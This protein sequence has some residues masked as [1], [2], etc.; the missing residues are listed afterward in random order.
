LLEEQKI[1]ATDATI[2]STTDEAFDAALIPLISQFSPEH[3]ETN[4][5]LAPFIEGPPGIGK[6]EVTCQMAKEL[7][8]TKLLIISCGVIDVN[9][10]F[11]GLPEIIRQA[12][13]KSE[14]LG[15]GSI[16]TVREV[17]VET[18]G[19][20]ILEADSS[21]EILTKWIKPE[22][23]AQFD[24]LGPDER[25]L[26]V[27]DDTHFLLERQQA[28]MMQLLTNNRTIHTH[29]V[30][31]GANVGIMFLANRLEDNAGAQ[32]MLAPVIDRIKRIVIN[33]D[34]KKQIVGWSEWAETKG[35]HPAVISF[36]RNTPEKLYT[37]SPDGATSSAADDGTQKFASPRGWAALGDEVST[38]ELFAEGG[39]EANAQLFTSL[40]AATPEIQ[41][42]L[43]AASRHWMTRSLSNYASGTV[44]N[45]AGVEFSSYYTVFSR[46]DLDKFLKSRNF[47]T[48]PVEE[49]PTASYRFAI[50]L[51]KRLSHLDDTLQEA[52]IY[53]IANNHEQMP[54]TS[55][56]S[57]LAKM[58]AKIANGADLSSFTEKDINSLR[59]AACVLM[60]IR[61]GY[62]N[63]P[64]KILKEIEITL[65][66][67]TSKSATSD[68]LNL[69][70][71]LSAKLTPTFKTLQRPG[72]E[73]EYIS[74]LVFMEDFLKHLDSAVPERR[75]QMASSFFGAFAAELKRTQKKQFTT[76]LTRSFSTAA[77]SLDVFIGVIL[78]KHP[79]L[80]DFLSSRVEI[81][82][83][84]KSRALSTPADLKA[85]RSKKARQDLS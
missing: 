13:K 27:F 8:I 73:K 24:S 32:D 64:S 72:L 46:Y 9:L 63:P 11:I 74:T 52:L 50:S 47:K 61:E 56:G 37:F 82:D 41:T 80:I 77:K 12:K 42:R 38:L 3:A 84:V 6:T 25:G 30:G 36:L 23:L 26:L 54:T 31:K 7:G 21:E 29:R 58:Y 49:L 69:E 60:S 14:A 68:N 40:P 10:E 53:Y 5:I 15:D 48:I 78:Q 45:E 85:S 62:I 55:A 59:D 39:R 43:A 67:T 2:V 51:A 16:A 17:D 83:L 81:S 76:E 20:K 34:P 44:G 22:R 70:K 65:S 66:E 18:G 71:L 75:A 57:S 1:M 35:V 79:E 4:H 33:L 28:M 19:S